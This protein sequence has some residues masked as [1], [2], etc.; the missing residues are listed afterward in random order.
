MKLQYFPDTDTLYIDIKDTTSID[1][2]VIAEGIVL[3][4]DEFGHLTGIEIDNAKQNIDLSTFET[5]SLPID[6]LVFSR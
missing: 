2:K 1:S 6:D 4:F 3:D 5:K